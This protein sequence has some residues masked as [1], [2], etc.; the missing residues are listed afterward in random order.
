MLVRQS[1]P[2]TALDVLRQGLSELNTENAI[3]EGSS[4]YINKLRY[5]PNSG[6]A[7][8]QVGTSN[9]VSAASQKTNMAKKGL[10]KVTQINNFTHGGTKVLKR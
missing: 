5:A 1:E 6:A 9:H 2:E 4:P 8:T 7:T 10:S 3:H